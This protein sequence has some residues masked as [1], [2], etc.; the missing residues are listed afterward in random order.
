MGRTESDDSAVVL[1]ES[2]AITVRSIRRLPSP[3]Q[4]DVNFLD[5]ACGLPWA[6]SGNRIKVQTESSQ[7]VPM[8]PVTHHPDKENSSDSDSS[9]SS[10]NDSQSGSGNIQAREER[11]ST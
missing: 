4:H 9:E 5:S 1:T 2:G 11:T 6:L 10:D 8:L 3:E 7:V